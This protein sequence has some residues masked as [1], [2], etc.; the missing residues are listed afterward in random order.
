M[1]R[2]GD[3]SWVISASD[4]TVLAQCPWRVARVTDEKLGKGIVVPDITDPMLQLV[5]RLGL[6]HEARQL[7]LLR[8]RLPRVV[9]I[10]YARDFPPSDVLRWR[11]DI[12]ASAHAT[13]EALTEGVDAIFQGVFYQRSLPESPFP[14]GFQGF[15]DF[16][17]NSDGTWEVWDTKLARSA[18]DSALIQLAAYANQLDVLGIP[19]SHEVRLIL[20]DGTNSIHD[21]TEL[22]PLYLDQ[23]SDLLSLMHERIQDPLP[24]PWDDERY[25]ACGTK[26]CPAC[27]EQIYIH[28]DL[29]QIA[30]LRKTQRDKIRVAGFSTMGSFAGASRTEVHQSVTGIGRDSLSMLHLQA[31]LQVATRKHPEGTPAWEI[32][33]PGV[34]A[35]IPEPNS[36]DIF[37][38][39]EGDPTY[40]EFNAEGESP[41]ALSH[42][43]ESWWFGIDYLFGMWGN[44][45]QDS[46][47]GDRFSFFWAESFAQEKVALERFCA[48]VEDR[49][50]RFPGMHVYHYAAYERTRLQ[51]M[52]TRHNTCQESVA[53]LLDGVLVD[54]YPIVMK[55]VR[56]GL[57]SYS[58]KSLEALYFNRYTRTGIAGGSESVVAFSHY[59]EAT[60]NGV[61]S[62]A[63][64]IRESIEHY[65]RLDCQSTEALRD[66]LLSIRESTPPS[67]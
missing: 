1:Q 57:P 27:G 42:G 51:A 55:G 36:G 45:L 4:L 33:S 12:E 16:L 9:E 59:L 52:A 24:T 35:L 8:S 61:D 48:L 60:R 19:R 66:W 65:N 56:V 5:A 39:F 26:G 23:R 53:R 62:V 37:F 28:D 30:G 38:D 21:V 14:V 31:S 6:E 49:L 44:E 58:L 20:G 40:Q 29:F 3:D 43:D 47:P 32:L 2:L 54:L 18:K 22:V 63:Q 50:A 64:T 41:G 34:L 46:I 7:E 10:T 13:K 15:A 67:L 11:A 17:V 25:R